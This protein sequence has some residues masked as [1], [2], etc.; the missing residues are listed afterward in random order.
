MSK[1]GLKHVAGHF[2]KNSAHGVGAEDGSGDGTGDGIIVGEHS[3]GD[4]SGE[5]LNIG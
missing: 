2:S 1:S 5:R 4:P 3:G